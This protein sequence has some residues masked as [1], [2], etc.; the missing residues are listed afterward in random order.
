MQFTRKIPARLLVL[1]LFI[2]IFVLF[3]DFDPFRIKYVKSPSLVSPSFFTQGGMNIFFYNNEKF[4]D[5]LQKENP[6]IKNIEIKRQF[7]NTIVVNYKQRKPFIIVMDQEQKEQFISDSDGVVYKK[8]AGGKTSLPILTTDRISLKKGV[9]LDSKAET[10][11]INII[12]EVIKQE[13]NVKEAVIE[14]DSLKLVI[15]G[16]NA[17]FKKDKVNL[18]KVESLQLLLKKFTIE[19]ELPEQIDL[20]FNKPIIKSE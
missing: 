1:M 14:K 19:G 17:I 15:N 8:A 11:S 4:A 18:A 2:E 5:Q 16:T 7:P 9:Y 12:K 3:A 6:E 13:L 20:R 10:S